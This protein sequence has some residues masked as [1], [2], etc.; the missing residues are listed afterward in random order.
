MEPGFL[1]FKVDDNYFFYILKSVIYNIVCLAGVL[2]W[3]RV[4]I[5][6]S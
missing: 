4:V 6:W 3:N 2:F 1:F 5:N